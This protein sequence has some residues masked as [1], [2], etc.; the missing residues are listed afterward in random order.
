MCNIINR[1][2][3]IVNG[4]SNFKMDSV[5]D[6]L[7]KVDGF[8]RPNA[9][10]MDEIKKEEEERIYNEQKN[11][12]KN[13]VAE[14]EM[15]QKYET[16]QLRKKRA[17]EKNHAERLKKRTEENNKYRAGELDTE[18][19]RNNLEKIENEYF[20]ASRKAESEYNKALSNLR[21]SNPKMY[22]KVV[23]NW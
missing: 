13:Q 12:A 5:E 14:D 20:E 11:A 9:A 15:R 7:N 18:D 2:A 17:D 23:R 21:T 10:M 16:L 22:D 8:S 6:D 3:G 1:T 4:V 19:H